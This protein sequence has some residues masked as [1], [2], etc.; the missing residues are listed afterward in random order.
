M[1]SARG[2]RRRWKYHP[3]WAKVRCLCATSICFSW[4]LGQTTSTPSFEDVRVSYLRN[5]RAGTQRSAWCVFS[6]RGGW[7]VSVTCSA[8][9]F[10]LS[11]WDFS[12]GQQTPSTDFVFHCSW[13]NFILKKSASLPQHVVLEKI[14]IPPENNDHVVPRESF[15]PHPLLSSSTCLDFIHH[16]HSQNIQLNWIIMKKISKLDFPWCPQG[17]VLKKHGRKRIAGTSH[18]KNW[19]WRQIQKLLW[20]TVGLSRWS[21]FLGAHIPPAHWEDLPT[22]PQCQIW[23]VIITDTMAA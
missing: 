14:A 11:V 16:N 9:Q 17:T 18:L 21:V 12:F 6:T 22:N 3:F 15:I 19:P 1:V 23:T 7:E 4:R 20:I 2:S 10:L 5:S 8:W 13:A